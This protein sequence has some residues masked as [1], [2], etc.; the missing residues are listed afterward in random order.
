MAP[1]TTSKKDLGVVT[2]LVTAKWEQDSFFCRDSSFSVRM[3]RPSPYQ[4]L[5]G[6]SAYFLIIIFNLIQ[7][8]LF[9][10]SQQIYT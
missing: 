8:F 4:D 7:F 6:V 1:S 5:Q 2:P 3:R 9:F 10:Y